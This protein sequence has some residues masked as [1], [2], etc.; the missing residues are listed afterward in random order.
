[1]YPFA[2][3]Q[4]YPLGKMNYQQTGTF[5]PANKNKL[6]LTKKQ[7]C[8]GQLDDWQHHGVSL[9]ICSTA[10]VSLTFCS[11]ARGQPDLWQQC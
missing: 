4:L 2:R 11:I 5:V 9:T 7:L 1:M 8:Y 6:V 3:V 10:R